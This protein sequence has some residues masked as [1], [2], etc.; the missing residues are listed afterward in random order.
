MNKAA[1]FLPL[2]IFIF[3]SSVIAETIGNISAVQG[4][5]SIQRGEQVLPVRPDTLI[6]TGDQ[7]ITPKGGKIRFRLRDNTRITLAE[8]TRFS[9]KRYQ[10]NAEK[11]TSDVKFKL[12]EGAF[13]AVTGAIGLQKKPVFEVETS[14]ATM[15]IR[16]TDFWGGFIFSDALDVTMISG[17]GVYI[18]NADG[19]V[20][21]TQAGQ[22]TTVKAGQAPGAV[23]SWP[24]SKLQRAI[25][26][27]ALEGDE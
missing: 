1:L 2:I 8:G 11:S 10:Y 4:S 26:T 21:L 6:Q 12:A 15:G 9:I 25:A 13:R 27:T 5:A 7:L 24:E 23:K 22:G 16:G 14:V 3:S 20:E 18:R 17:K 19:Q